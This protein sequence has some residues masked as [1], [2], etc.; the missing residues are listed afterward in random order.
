MDVLD[1]AITTEAYSLLHPVAQEFVWGTDNSPL[2]YLNEN[3][4][5]RSAIT[6]WNP[7]GSWRPDAFN[8]LKAISLWPTLLLP[9]N[10]V[11]PTFEEFAADLKIVLDKS[12]IWILWSEYDFDQ[13][14]LT[15]ATFSTDRIVS[16]VLAALADPT[17]LDV[18]AYSSTATFLRSDP[19]QLP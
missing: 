11:P 5:G 15:E 13:A 9:S 10:I 1:I 6:P 8:D 17:R 16:E 3:V 2:L 12:H 7:P 4:F 18:V 19:L 14:P